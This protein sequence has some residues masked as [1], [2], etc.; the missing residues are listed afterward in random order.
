MWSLGGP[1][2]YG[3]GG[4]TN[5]CIIWTLEYLLGGLYRTRGGGVTICFE[6]TVSPPAYSF[7]FILWRDA[8]LTIGSMVSFA[9]SSIGYRLWSRTHIFVTAS[10]L[11]GSFGPHQW[12]YTAPGS[13]W[14]HSRNVIMNLS[15]CDYMAIPVYHRKIFYHPQTIIPPPPIRCTYDY[16]TCRCFCSILLPH[17]PLLLDFSTKYLGLTPWVTWK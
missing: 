15:S 3:G 11:P 10:T 14:V 2:V 9:S 6:G 12:H 8:Y 13:G 7:I 5:I 1:W 4:V 16:R 17:L